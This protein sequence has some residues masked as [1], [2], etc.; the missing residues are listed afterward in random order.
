DDPI[1][2]ID[3]E[4]EA[5]ANAT[6]LLPNRMVIGL[7]AWRKIK[8][9]AEVL[10][11]QSGTSNKAVSLEELAGM[12]LNPM[13]DIRVGVM[14]YDTAKMG[15]AA[16][17]QNVVGSEIFIFHGNDN[18]TQYDPGFAKTFSIGANSVEDVRMY[19]EEKVRSDIL[20]VDW[21]EDVKVIST[22]CAK[23]IQ[24]A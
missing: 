8:N 16:N 18:P 12:L 20:A 24:V 1:D 10:K 5:I 17:K 4:I 21:S 3:A 13:I 9:H 11:R 7:G 23:R 6:G 2:L 14:A 22:L 19:R 15:K